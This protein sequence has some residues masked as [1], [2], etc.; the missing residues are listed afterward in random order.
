V[1]PQ[2]LPHP[3]PKEQP[4]ETPEKEREKVHAE[5]REFLGQRAYNATETGIQ[6]AAKF[7][8]ISENQVGDMIIA[9]ADRI[10]RVLD[11]GGLG[12]KQIRAAR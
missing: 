10:I 6:R 9:I 11:V 3:A 1:L 4:V 7:L 2:T 8:G 12:K 5:I